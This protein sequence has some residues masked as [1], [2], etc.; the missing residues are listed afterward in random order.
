MNIEKKQKTKKP[1]KKKTTLNLDIN[2]INR[3]N[4]LSN[5]ARYTQ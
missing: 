4:L 2:D 5:G 1:K 3:D